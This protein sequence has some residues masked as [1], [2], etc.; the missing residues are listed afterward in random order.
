[1]RK[2]K[3]TFL[4]TGLLYGLYSFGQNDTIIK[5]Q[6]VNIATL[7]VD[8]ST[9]SFEG[10]DMAYYSC[11][12]CAGDSIPFTIDYEYPV[13]FGGV[14]FTLTPL[15]DTIFDA[16]II[17]AGMGKI[18]YP[19]QFS[20][21]SLFTDSNSTV[22]RPRDLRYIN[23]NGHAISDTALLKRA[24]SAWNVINSLEVTSRFA[25]KGFETA[26]YLYPPTVGMFNP[27]VAKWIVFLYHKGKRLHRSHYNH[28]PV[29]LSPNPTEGPLRVQW[30]AG[31]SGKTHYT[32]F[33]ATGKPLRSGEYLGKTHRLDLSALKPGIY[34]IHL[35]TNNQD[36]VSKRIVVK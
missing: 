7:V 36:V 32:I 21:Q 15:Q 14:T 5:D 10:G 25:Q 19:S 22:N 8:Y 24:D 2:L 9:Y 31:Q 3:A 27:H 17:W 34:M 35:R 12:G 23:T 4:L 13:D 6:Y 18:R 26:I 29:Q 30:P 20:K 1:M 11:S 16:S 28:K 33:S